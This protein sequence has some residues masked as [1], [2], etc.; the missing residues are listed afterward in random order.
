MIWC[1]LVWYDIAS[2]C[3]SLSVS[4]NTSTMGTSVRFSPFLS[5][6]LVSLIVLSLFF[7]CTLLFF[8]CPPRLYPPP[9][10][11]LAFCCSSAVVQP[12]A[13][14]GRKGGHKPVDRGFGGV[15]S[16][17]NRNRKNHSRVSCQK[18]CMC[19]IPQVSE[20]RRTGNTADRPN[21]EVRPTVA[22]SYPL[23]SYTCSDVCL[24]EGWY[25]NER[26]RPCMPRKHR[27]HV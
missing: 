13:H 7:R 21:V 23:Y 10:S 15:R 5:G 25:V 14:G 20:L 24:R 2:A 17:K 26:H 12:D 11:W 9:R 8:C 18:S 27:L 3:L 16:R 6:N 4:L 1:G 22:C 19:N